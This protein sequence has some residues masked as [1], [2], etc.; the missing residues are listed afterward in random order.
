MNAKIQ[1]AQIGQ[2]NLH[3]QCCNITTGMWSSFDDTIIQ[4]LA[5]LWC[6]ASKVPAAS[7]DEE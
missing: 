7:L 5:G 6:S 3:M 2:V 4:S 1:S